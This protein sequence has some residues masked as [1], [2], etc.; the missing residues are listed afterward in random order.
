FSDEADV[1]SDAVA[2]AQKGIEV[3]QG[4]ITRHLDDGHRGELIREGFQVVLAGPPNVGKS[5]LLN[6]L[7]RRDVAIVSEEAGTTRD[8]IEVKL[9]LDGLPIVVSDTAG[10]REATGKVEEEGIRRTLARAQAADLVL[11]LVDAMVL[12]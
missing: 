11:W 1:V 7:A 10:I 9:D 2:R 3:L 6:A 12:D 5:S 8:V 4:Q